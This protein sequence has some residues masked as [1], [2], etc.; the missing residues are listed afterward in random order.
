MISLSNVKSFGFTVLLAMSGATALGACTVYTQDRV[1]EYPTTRVSVV[2]VN[3]ETYPSTEYR[4]S[5]AYLVEGR[6]YYRHQGRW[7]VFDREPEELTRYRTNYHTTPRENQR[8]RT[9]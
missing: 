5:S 2:P 1:G 4:G 6:W 3:I 7:V 9:Q 8:Y